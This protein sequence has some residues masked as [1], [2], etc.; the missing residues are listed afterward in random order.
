MRNLFQRLK[1]FWTAISLLLCLSPTTSW[2]ERAEKNDMLAVGVL[3]EA[4]AAGD[5]TTVKEQLAQ[6]LE[7]DSADKNGITPLLAASLRGRETMVAY[8]LKK[9]ATVDQASKKGVTPLSMATFSGSLEVVRRLLD[10]GAAV[11]PPKAEGVDSLLMAVMNNRLSILNLFLERGADG[12]R[13]YPNG[14]SLLMVAAKHSET[15]LLAR[16][17]EE[18]A[19]INAKGRIG[20]E[21]ALMLA[22][23]A[24]KNANV[25]L[26]LAHGADVAPSDFSYRNA[27]ERAFAAGQSDAALLLIEAGARLSV[28]FLGFMANG[29][30]VQLANGIK[31]LFQAAKDGDDSAVSALL[32]AGIPINPQN[33]SGMTPLVTAASMGHEA[34]VKQLLDAGSDPNHQSDWKRTPLITAASMGHEAVVKQLLDAG[35]DPN[36][37]SD[38]E[39]TPLSVAASMG[40]EAVVKQLLEMESVLKHQPDYLDRAI[41]QA[42][43]NDHLGVLSLLI[44]AG[45]EHS[46]ELERA[47]SKRRRAMA[48]TLMTSGVRFPAWK[49]WSTGTRHF[50]DERL[51]A[52]DVAFFRQA[53]AAGLEHKFEIYGDITTLIHKALAKKQLELAR[54]FIAAGGRLLKHNMNHTRGYLLEAIKAGQWQQIALYKQA[55]FLFETVDWQGRTLLHEA[56]SLQDNEA[57]AAL[58][59]AGVP[60]NSAD[61]DGVSPLMS[62]A[63][64]G[65]R[66]MTALLLNKGAAAGPDILIWVA[67]RGHLPVAKLLLQSGADVNGRTPSGDSPLY[68][69]VAYGHS[70]M[71]ALL[72]NNG[73]DPAIAAPE[74]SELMNSLDYALE[75]R[76]FGSAR[77][78]ANAWGKAVIWPPGMAKSCLHSISNDKTDFF[79]FCLE[80][81]LHEQEGVFKDNA[82][83]TA[84]EKG[85]DK[86]VAQLLQAGVSGLERRDDRGRTPL[87]L[88]ATRGDKKIVAQLAARGANLQAHGE[89]GLSLLEAAAESDSTELIED[90]LGEQWDYLP[91]AEDISDAWTAAVRQGDL[92]VVRL[93]LD[94][95]SAKAAKLAAKKVPFE[96]IG[97]PLEAT[98]KMVAKSVPIDKTGTA[99]VVAI[100][101]KYQALLNFFVERGWRLEEEN[102]FSPF[103]A[104][105]AFEGNWRVAA[106]LLQAG[107]AAN[108]FDE[109]GMTP[110]LN[111]AA[112]GL[113]EMT[114]QLLQKGA[115]ADLK[116]QDG[117]GE[118]PL[119]RAII[120][121]HIDVVRRLLD[122]G[123]DADAKSADLRG[124]T[125]LMLAAEGGQERIAAL[126]LERGADPTLRDRQQRN[127][128][129]RLVNRQNESM[130]EERREALHDLFA[131][132]LAKRAKVLPLPR[133][134]LENSNASFDSLALSPDGRLVAAVKRIGPQPFKLLEAASGR[135]IRSFQTGDGFSAEHLAFFADGQRVLSSGDRGVELWNITTGERI[136]HF[137]DERKAVTSLAVDGR[138]A[139]SGDDY[140][141]LF[142]WEPESGK[143]LR[144]LGTLGE[145]EQAHTG[146]GNNI[147]AV[148][149]SPDGR[150][151][152]SASRY[153]TVKLWDL[154]SGKERWSKGKTYDDALFA[155]NHLAFVENDKLALVSSD[156]NHALSLWD[157]N[158]GER[159]ALFLGHTA[160]IQTLAITADGLL[161]ASGDDDGIIRLWSLHRQTAAGHIQGHEG[162]VQGIAFSPD[163][164][165][166]ASV[167]DDGAL[168]LWEPRTL[169]EIKI[170]KPPHSVAEFGFL[171]LAFTPDDRE[172]LLHDGQQAVRWDR[173]TGKSHTLFVHDQHITAAALADDGATAVFID[174]KNDLQWWSLATEERLRRDQLPPCHDIWGTP[175]S[176][177]SFRYVFFLNQNNE[178]VKQKSRLLLRG[179][180]CDLLEWN[181]HA[182]TLLRKI[183]ENFDDYFVNGMALAADEKKV[184]VGDTG[185]FRLRSLSDGRII[186]AYASDWQGRPDINKI[187]VSAQGELAVTPSISGQTNSRVWN[188]KT[189]R[190][191]HP[192]KGAMGDHALFAPDD[193]TLF[194]WGGNARPPGFWNARNGSLLTHLDLKSAGWSG[195]HVAE[196]DALAERLNQVDAAAFNLDGRQLFTL[197]SDGMR[198]W[199][200]TDGRMEKFWQ[201]NLPLAVDLDI[202]ADGRL[203][204]SGGTA[205][206]L[207]DLQKGRMVRTFANDQPRITRLLLG[208]H[209]LL[210]HHVDGRIRIWGL[211][212]GAL[213]RTLSV[214]GKELHLSPD[215]RWGVLHNDTG[216]MA[217]LDLQTMQVLTHFGERS[218]TRLAIAPLSDGQTVLIANKRGL[219]PW[220][221]LKDQPLPLLEHE[222]LPDDMN[223]YKRQVI[224]SSNGRWLAVNGR[225]D[226]GKVADKGMEDGILIFDVESGAMEHNLFGAGQ[227]NLLAMAFDDN[228]EKKHLLTV[229]SGGS[230]RRWDLETGQMIQHDQ[231]PHDFSAAAFFADQRRLL[232]AAFRNYDIDGQE[233]LRLWHLENGKS[234]VRRGNYKNLYGSVLSP[235][236]TLLATLSVQQAD[237]FS[238]TL[239]RRVQTLSELYDVTALAISADN[240]YLLTGHINNSVALWDLADGKRLKLFFAPDSDFVGWDYVG[241]A[242]TQRD[243]DDRGK[244]DDAQSKR[245]GENDRIVA[246][247]L[248]SQGA[249]TVF[250][251]NR[252]DGQ[253]A[254]PSMLDDY[255]SLAVRHRRTVGSGDRYITEHIDYSIKNIDND[256]RQLRHFPD[257]EVL[258][259][260]KNNGMDSLA[261][262]SDGRRIVSG[263]GSDLELLDAKNG[264][265]LKTVKTE[266]EEI[267]RT[268]LAQKG[269]LAASADDKGV[270][271]LWDLKK[272]RVIHRLQGDHTAFS[273]NRL[274]F[275]HQDRVLLSSDVYG[276]HIFWDVAGGRRL[277]TLNFFADGSWVAVDNAGRYDSNRPG[278][279]PALSWVMTDDPLRP[280]PL[281]LFM[282]DYYEPRL[283]PRLLAGETFAKAAPL[284]SI[285]RAQ[286]SVRILA[287]TPEPEQSWQVQVQVAVASG[288]HT[289]HL[290]GEKRLQESGAYDLRL[291]RDGQL[292]DY[293]PRLSGKR[294]DGESDHNNEPGPVAAVGEKQIITF[295]NVKISTRSGEGTARGEGSPPIR[296]SAYAFNVDG[297]KSLTHSF[298]HQAASAVIKPRPRRAYLLAIG[299]N[300]YENPAWNLHY[301][302]NDARVIRHRLQCRLRESGH[303]AEVAVI[304]LISEKVN[305]AGTGTTGESTLVSAPADKKQIRAVLDRLAGKA[306]D[307]ELLSAIPGAE[308]LQEANPEDLVMI[309]YSGHGLAV[310]DG[311]FHLFPH[312]IGP[313]TQRAVDDSL[314]QNTLSSDRL[315]QWLRDVDA[316][317]MVMI[318][319]ACNSAA[320][321]EGSGFKPGPM[322]SRGLGQLA[323]DKG[324]R[325]LT[326]SQAEGLALESDLIRHGVLT[327]ALIR[328]GLDG[329]YADFMPQD[330]QITVG[331]WLRFGLKRVPDLY[332]EVRNGRLTLSLDLPKQTGAPRGKVIRF[333]AGKSKREIEV[334]EPGLFDFNRHRHGTVMARIASAAGG[335]S[336]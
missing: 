129:D 266:G 108:G 271:H 334:Q 264:K 42:V 179:Y 193:K 3:I 70:D 66:D 80:M 185:R 14:Q 221:A 82:L 27:A 331:E 119:M 139:L 92:P 72:L 251:W 132:V 41:A 281:E 304:S 150:Y 209:S 157:L 222:P 318:I 164:R 306:V 168:R 12:Q 31:N 151:G 247:W 6:G 159:R 267:R 332:R 299:V 230:I 275:I 257:G 282:K 158:S 83:L 89:Y 99:A 328:E 226:V 280:L 140:G 86:V 21:T 277:A 53:L 94:R 170:K 286:P 186:R 138:S 114:Q 102:Q 63:G 123:A 163:G 40:H 210:S 297:I 291:F 100:R 97:T 313:G 223:V 52:G 191:T 326:A 124:V 13:Y 270:I 15:A 46:G 25:S 160:S 309:T 87:L 62:A 51:E 180:G 147:V 104:R 106:L 9:G 69:A 103:L 217:L 128:L 177:F 19:D 290:E 190:S 55:G 189:G 242:S 268:A 227:K 137:F 45:G 148:A 166:L 224:F 131:A 252:A 315:S 10:H 16:L 323:Y 293:A 225:M 233:K 101:Q 307:P 74:G 322:G 109:A 321:V 34:V 38:L 300:A 187:V 305:T 312:D 113:A 43:S 250:A 126:L 184:L 105:A 195:K 335:A 254:A 202:S 215:R 308:R 20:G 115:T 279:L 127:A 174:Y 48:L 84:I 28:D 33:D 244:E 253:P 201:H 154:S 285:N 143:K 188:L 200:V 289:L 96:K 23:E 88:A 161:A 117:R 298:D 260:L 135:E 90:L 303:F 243:P 36:H 134:I 141:R 24:G 249:A 176:G 330:Q 319:D 283:L 22:A 68:S 93:F 263:I 91:S 73:A 59:A 121:G 39:E 296:F 133:L 237:I 197:H 259:T 265:R 95:E 67:E 211:D 292:V 213:Q 60:M 65:R 238:L 327:Y 142:L 173:Q 182:G 235:D 206:H 30:A 228:D 183:P 258:A 79:E 248:R 181:L 324:M 57:A 152:A 107:V 316:G 234:E 278:D 26:L 17:L 232:T 208:D 56:V 77:L 167:G 7:V 294:V 61:S 130:G 110:L 262:S 272:N 301:A 219:Q 44:A 47:L 336:P 118:T 246:G 196:E 116:S 75:I 199:S 320:G 205:L 240:R 49:T 214:R 256:R 329:N 245:E 241:F 216:E 149:L 144:T 175:S 325:I 178:S 192:L 171:W 125:P 71:A 29:S 231:A 261:F 85:K 120:G 284:N 273:I 269:H 37:K 111:A 64:S 145:L 198:R 11:K 287:V 81:G 162:G 229:S 207:W 153:D 255:G 98:I 8:L 50:I 204:L 1:F 302:A 194:V 136:R 78:L 2:S 169:Q 146:D 112:N 5:L 212:D 236:R 314:L 122:A 239:G 288:A 317:E 274:H 165:Q 32:A 58:I 18:K 54:L 203:A 295:R 172:I 35:S 333:N 310:S 156:D 155:I 76:D 218:G 4:A 276:T 311:A 220:S